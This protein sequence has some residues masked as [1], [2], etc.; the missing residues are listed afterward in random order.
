MEFTQI[1]TYYSNEEIE[2]EVLGAWDREQKALF[3]LGECNGNNEMVKI[4]NQ[5]CVLCFENPSV[6]AFRICGQHNL[7]EN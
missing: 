2:E 6:Y 5:K 3:K 7:C 1:H 4:F